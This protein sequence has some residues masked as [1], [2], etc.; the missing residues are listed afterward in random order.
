MRKFEGLLILLLCIGCKE[1]KMDLV[2]V[3][4]RNSRENFT[5]SNADGLHRSLDP[6]EYQLKIKFSNSSTKPSSI[7][8]TKPSDS[9]FKEKLQANLPHADEFLHVNDAMKIEARDLDQNFSMIITR[10]VDIREDHIGISFFT[11]DFEILLATAEFRHKSYRSAYDERSGEFLQSYQ[12]VKRSQRGVF[13]PI[14]GD[15]DDNGFHSEILD[16]VVNF[17]GMVLVAPWVYFRY[18][19]VQWAL[20]DKADDSD[21]VRE[22]WRRL[23]QKN[24][25]IDYF[26]FT[27]GGHDESIAKHLDRLRRKEIS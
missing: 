20:G 27:H 8:I 15:I 17:A 23:V 4:D 3:S 11:P 1:V 13:V 10:E 6:G 26:A 7:E 22:R 16:S 2:V 19:N 24:P 5:F 14:D 18:S 21:Y 25:V 12:A 9:R